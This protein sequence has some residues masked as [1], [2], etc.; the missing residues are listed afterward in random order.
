MTN[1][2]KRYQFPLYP[3]INQKRPV[4][5]VLTKNNTLANRG[6]ASNWYHQGADGIYLWNLGVPLPHPHPHPHPHPRRRRRDGQNLTEARKQCYGSLTHLENNDIL[7]TK[8][9]I[10]SV[11]GPIFNSYAHIPGKAPLPQTLRPE[12]DLP[13][14]CQK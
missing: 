3:S 9:T 6:P 5:E 11:D 8:D 10:S 13:I 7:Q 12:K 4:Y 14:N 2:A 1:L